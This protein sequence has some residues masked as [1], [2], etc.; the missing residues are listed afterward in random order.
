MSKVRRARANGKTPVQYWKIDD[1]S[2]ADRGVWPGKTAEI[3]IRAMF[4]DA[5]DDGKPRTEVAVTAVE[6][7]TE[8]KMEWEGGDGWE[9]ERSAVLWAGSGRIV[10]YNDDDDLGLRAVALVET[11]AGD[12]VALYGSGRWLR[13]TYE[14]LTFHDLAPAL[15]GEALKRFLILMNHE[16]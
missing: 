13:F 15:T 2:G 16:P 10:G 5:D 12:H 6:D 4:Q 3:A 7:L 8:I 11:G 1:T 9:N 14:D